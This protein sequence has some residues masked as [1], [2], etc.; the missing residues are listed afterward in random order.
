MIKT[1]LITTKS[2]KQFKLMAAD[3]TAA[4]IAAKELFTPE[5]PVNAS[6]SDEW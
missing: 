2:G 5:H 1:Y 3:K 4:L 6:L